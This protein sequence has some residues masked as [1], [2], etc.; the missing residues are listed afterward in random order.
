MFHPDPRI[1]I[2]AHCLEQ[3]SNH[4]IKNSL[5][6]VVLQLNRSVETTHNIKFDAIVSLKRKHTIKEKKHLLNC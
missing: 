6:S 2:L 3:G 4:V 5:V 1:I